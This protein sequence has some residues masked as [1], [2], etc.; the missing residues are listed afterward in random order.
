LTGPLAEVEL[1]NELDIYHYG[2]ELAAFNDP[3]DWPRDDGEEDGVNL[4][5]LGLHSVSALLSL[6][7]YFGATGTLLKKVRGSAVT[8]SRVGFCPIFDANKHLIPDS[9]GRLNTEHSSTNS[10][11]FISGLARPMRIGSLPDEFFDP[12]RGYTITII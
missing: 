3:D 7:E 4:T 2:H 10:K 5:F 6:E 1:S 12:E 9:E 11:S 8:F